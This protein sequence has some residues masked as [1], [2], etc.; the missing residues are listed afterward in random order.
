MSANK[1]NE[2][3]IAAGRLTSE[4]ITKL[5]EHWQSGNGLTVDGYAGPN[6]LGS[7]ST[8][9]GIAKHFPL[10]CL[11]DGRRPVITSKFRDENPS[12][13]THNGVDFLFAWEDGDPLVKIGDGGAAGR[14]G[15][16]RYWIPEGTYAVA[17]AR[18]IVQAADSSKTGYRIW[19]DHGHGERTG[20]FHLK[21]CAVMQGDLVAAGDDLGIVG[22]NPAGHD[23]THLHFEVSPSDRYQPINPRTWLDG[24]LY[25]DAKE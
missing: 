16:R 25:L 15:V 4:M 23:A 10:R 8:P 20:Y 19:I 9:S 2:S 14:K 13:S 21:N 17:A 12:R 22:D 18:G 5:V 7:L 11:A 1:Y 6:T 3:Q 24:A